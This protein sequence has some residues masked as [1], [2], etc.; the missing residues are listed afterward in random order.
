MGS[1]KY[2]VIL[3]LFIGEFTSAQSRVDSLTQRL[4]HSSGI[5]KV[6]LLNELTYEF[7]TKDNTK[8][9]QYCD[10]ALSLGTTLGYQKGIGCSYTYRGVYEYLSGEYSDGR[11]N[12]RRGLKLAIKSND[13]EN[14]GY[15]LIQMGNSFLN[16]TQLDSSLYFFN[17]SYAIL[18]DSANPATLSKL[19]RNLGVLYGIRS[20]DDLQKKYLIRA[21]RIRELLRDKALLADALIVF[22]RMNIKSNDYQTAAENLNKAKK[23]VEGNAGYTESLN[24]W[25]HQQALVLLHERK[26]DQAHV[27]FDSAIKYYARNSLLQKYVTVQTDLAR[28]FNDRGEY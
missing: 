28:I 6:D 26:F 7:I 27:L 12:L 3:F 10:Q 20:Q 14:Q 21:I 15:S 24:D 5:Q 9:M 19:Y 1:I 25:R 11:T 2:T 18:K 8:A 23:I 22:A 4:K 13:S 17:Q 16:Q